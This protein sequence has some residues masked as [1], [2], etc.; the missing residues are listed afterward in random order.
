MNRYP[1]SRQ[2][3]KIRLLPRHLKAVIK[4]LESEFVHEGVKGGAEV[5]AD[6]ANK[7][8]ED[9]RRMERCERWRQDL[10]AVSPL[11]QLPERLKIQFV[12]NSLLISSLGLGDPA[13]QISK[14]FLCPS[15]S[16]MMGRVVNRPVEEHA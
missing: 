11:R 13:L 6:L 2:P 12:Q 15:K 5:V 1:T 4:L 7:D 14:V 10:K 3:L 8:A 9:R 16:V